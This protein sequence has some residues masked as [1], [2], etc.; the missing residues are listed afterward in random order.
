MRFVSRSSRPPSSF[1]LSAE[2]RV[3]PAQPCRSVEPAAPGSQPLVCTLRGLY[4]SFLAAARLGT[5][6][7]AAPLGFSYLRAGGAG[8][9]ADGAEGLG[10]A[11]VAAR[12]A[13]RAEA[14]GGRAD[15]AG[16]D[17]GLRP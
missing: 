13:P 7:D 16:A 12:E 6:A 3:P 15:V 2:E 9:A 11:A 1:A 8:R 17:G 14:D 5:A 4:P 10:A